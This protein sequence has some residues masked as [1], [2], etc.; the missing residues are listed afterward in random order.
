[1]NGMMLVARREIGTQIRTRAFKIGL[2]ITAVLGGALVVE[3]RAAVVALA[4][5]YPLVR[6]CRKARGGADPW[7]AAAVAL[8]VAGAAAGAAGGALGMVWGW[9][10]SAAALG[11]CVA[12]AALRALR[13]WWR[14]TAGPWRA[15][16][17]M[18]DLPMGGGPPVALDP[19]VRQAF[20]YARSV[21]LSYG[22]PLGPRVVGAAASMTASGELKL[23][24][25]T[26]AWEAIEDD[27][28][29]AVFAADPLQRRSWVEVRGI[30]LADAD[31][32]RVTPKEV[33]VGQFPGRHQRR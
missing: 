31:V 26:G 5:P 18:C 13:A 29:V 9:R 1:M 15:S 23:I 28:R 21:V 33:L 14:G 17:T 6:A 2:L 32:L 8:V 20:A 4:V 30:A 11:A 3:P 10:G 22:D 19:E 7:L 25:G 27:P 12:V 16:L 24:A